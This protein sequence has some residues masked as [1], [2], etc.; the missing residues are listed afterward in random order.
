MTCLNMISLL[1][2]DNNKYCFHNIWYIYSSYMQSDINYLM[3][4]LKIYIKIT[5]RLNSVYI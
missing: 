1:D 4:V 5:H 3:H 2:V